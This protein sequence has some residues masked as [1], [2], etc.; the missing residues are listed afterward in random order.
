MIEL[1]RD[2][3]NGLIIKPLVKLIIGLISQEANVL[4]AGEGAWVVAAMI[5]WA[6]IGTIAGIFFGEFSMVVGGLIA[7]AIFGAIYGFFFRVDE[8]KKQTDRSDNFY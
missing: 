7:G 1:I 5:V 8:R 4:D 6:V 3:I 2:L